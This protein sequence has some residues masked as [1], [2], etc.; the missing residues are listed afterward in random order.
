MRQYRIPRQVQN[1]A[2][3]EGVHSARPYRTGAVRPR[4]K[5]A[6]SVPVVPRVRG[7]RPVPNSRRWVSSA[8]THRE[9][10]CSTSHFVGTSLSVFVVGPLRARVASPV[11]V[12]QRHRSILWR[13]KGGAPT[14]APWVWASGPF[15]SPLQAEATVLLFFKPNTPVQPI[16]IAWAIF[17]DVMGFESVWKQL[18]VSEAR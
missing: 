5:T 9:G 2:G 6:G 13:V 7:A 4:C 14:T 11:C 18:R 1:C 8:E 16:P 3:G 10:L 12:L 15:G 17:L